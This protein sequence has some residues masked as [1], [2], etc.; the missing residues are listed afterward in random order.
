LLQV[1]AAKIQSNH[2]TTIGANVSVGANAVVHACAIGDNV[3]VGDG[4]QVLDGATVMAWAVVAPGAVV[5]PGKVVGTGELWSGTPAKLLRMLTEAEKAAIPAAA[6]EAAVLAA[7][8]QNECGKGYLEVLADI[9][10]ATDLEERHVDYFPRVSAIAQAL[11]PRPN[12]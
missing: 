3:L 5:G 1:H 9:E 7:I 4:A 10:D 12:E 8:H 11:G 6:Q 2:A